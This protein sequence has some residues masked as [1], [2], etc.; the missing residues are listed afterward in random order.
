MGMTRR[1]GLVSNCWKVQLDQ[2]QSLVELIGHARDRGFGAIELRQGCLGELNA[3]LPIAA[4]ELAAAVSFARLPALFPE[5]Q[6]NLAVNLP[7]FRGDSIS[8]IPELK[9]YLAAARALGGARGPQLRIVDIQTR[10]PHLD[11]VLR[12][13]S[14]RALQELA[15]H[16]DQHG[17]ALAVEN[18]Y[19][20]WDTFQAVLDAANVDGTPIRCCL[21]PCNLLLSESLPVVAQVVRS[22]APASVAM[23]HLKQQKNQA[24]QPD[25]RE[26]EIDWSDLIRSLGTWPS[27][28]PWLFEL[29]PDQ[30]LWK[31]LNEAQARVRSMIAS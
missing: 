24:I 8:A 13:Q 15:R 30:D 6:F 16:L 31:H 23:V 22:V 21:D 7:C 27:S 2:G 1:L 14:A 5:L 9:S 29:A 3:A 4:T 17:G 18:G 20:S 11:A 12:T 10:T 26:G 19:Q 25:F 28:I